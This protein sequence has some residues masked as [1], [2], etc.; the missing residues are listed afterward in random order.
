MIS[1]IQKSAP[2]REV[3]ALPFG[4]IGH[5]EQVRDGSRHRQGLRDRSAEARRSGKSAAKGSDFG[6]HRRAS[7]RG[8]RSGARGARKGRG[9][10]N[11]RRLKLKKGKKSHLLFF[12]HP[13]AWSLWSLSGLLDHPG[14]RPRSCSCQC[15]RRESS[16][17]APGT[18]NWRL[19]GAAFFVLL[20]FEE[21]GDDSELEKKSERRHSFFSLPG[22]SWRHRRR[23]PSCR[24]WRG[25]RGRER[26]GPRP[27]W[28]RC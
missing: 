6:G 24:R 15:A 16:A 14:A 3:V 8:A 10:K 11:R 7:P 17:R 13:R 4:P 20:L 2:P 9:S 23:R 25:P 5:S 21:S 19:K 18:K 27:W 22:A 28:R 1:T 12:S 26:G